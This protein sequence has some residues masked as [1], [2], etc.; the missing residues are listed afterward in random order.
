VFNQRENGLGENSLL[1]VPLCFPFDLRH[2]TLASS[3]KV[4]SKSVFGRQY[5]IGEIIVYMTL[6]LAPIWISNTKN[7]L[8]VLS[9][10]P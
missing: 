7:H 10:E 1:D 8:V 4:F 3:L 5:K 2:V 6:L 9:A